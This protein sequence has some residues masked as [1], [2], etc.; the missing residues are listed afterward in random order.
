M[1]ASVV[2]VNDI[3][4]G[5]VKLDIACLDRIYLNVYMPK[6]PVRGASRLRPALL[7]PAE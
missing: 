5:Q 2:T 6:W 7:V 3:L 1:G 4:D